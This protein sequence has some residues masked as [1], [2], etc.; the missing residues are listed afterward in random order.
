VTRKVQGSNARTPDVFARLTEPNG[1]F[2]VKQQ[3]VAGKLM[4][5]FAGGPSSLQDAFLGTRDFGDATALSYGDERWSY[6]HQWQLVVSVAAALTG[7]FAIRRGDRV[8]IVARNYPEWCFSFWAI[9]LAGAVAVPLNAW[10][11]GAE[12]GV[13]LEDCQPVVL[14]ADDERLERR[15]RLPTTVRGVIGVRLPTPRAGVVPFEEL[16]ADRGDTRVPDVDIGSGDIATIVYTSGTTGRPK[17]VVATHLNHTSTLMSMRLRA[18]VRAATSQRPIARSGATLLPFPMFHV[19]GLTGMIS[20]AYAGR[21]VVLMYRWDAASAV[22]LIAREQA[23]D[24]TGPPAVVKQLLDVLAESNTEVPSLTALGTGGGATPPRLI[25]QIDEYFGGRVSPG[26]GYGLTETTSAIFAISGQ[27][28]LDRPTSLGYPLPTVEI[29]LRDGEGNA[30]A[31][32]EMGELEIRG[33]QIA[34]GYLNLPKVTSEAF[35][36][37][38]FRTGDLAR[39]DADGYFYLV[40]RLTDIVIRGGENVYPPEVE[41]VIQDHPAVLEA[42]VF[43]RPHPT[44]GEE[45]CAVIRL[46]PGHQL[47]ATELRGYLAERIAHFKIPAEIRYT[48]AP[49]PRNPTGKILKAPLRAMVEQGEASWT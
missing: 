42:A 37:G 4:T 47:P 8:A 36:D 49:L 40:G 19:A 17:G 22:S 21:H 12:L 34:T 41:E 15:P 48:D 31:A 46:T 23:Q 10:L 32:G 29:R 43:G 28:L 33:P 5:V 11:T 39:Q 25:R 18:A 30:V 2:P 38:W 24:M 45:V 6:E 35:C 26:T 9:Q 14:I 20:H 3:L 44:L 1:P 16:A 7:R 27:D 13:L